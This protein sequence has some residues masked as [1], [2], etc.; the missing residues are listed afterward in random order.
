MYFAC[1]TGKMKFQFTKMKKTM[2]GISCKVEI[3][4]KV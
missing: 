1:T 3:K 2:G 4:N